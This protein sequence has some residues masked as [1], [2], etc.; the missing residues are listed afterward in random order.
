MS[1]VFPINADPRFRIYTAEDGQTAF[2]VPFPWQDNADIKILRTDLDDVTTTLNEA[3]HYQLTGAGQ[4]GGGTMT[5]NE[6]E[7]A[8]EG[9]EFLILG[10]ASLVRVSSIVQGG[11]FRYQGTDNDLDRLTII[12][13]E[14]ER[15]LGRALRTPYGVA[16]AEVE[17]GTD[18]TLARWVGGR[19][20]PGPIWG[21]EIG[22]IP[23]PGLPPGGTPGQV[24]VRV[25]GPDYETEWQ[26]P[27]S[28][29]DKLPLDGSSPLT[30]PIRFTHQG[31]PANPAAGLLSLFAKN[32]NK[33]YSR[34]ADGTER[35]IG[36]G[37]GGYT[38]PQDHN[39]VVD[40]VANDYA[41]II[42]ARDYAIANGLSLAFPDGN[43][44]YGTTLE[45]A[46][47]GLH[48]LALG[49]AVNLI[50][51]GSGRAVSFNG[52][53]AV[54]MTIAAP[55]VV[56]WA[57]NT[58]ADGNLITFETT[59]ALPTGVTAGTGYYVKN[60]SGNTFE[61]SATPGGASINTTGSQSGVHTG[62]VERYDQSFGG[63][64][65][66]NIR[67]NANTTDLLYTNNVH[68]S[69]FRADVRDGSA[70]WR[71]LFA[72]CNTYDIR[73]SD[74]TGAFA[75]QPFWGAFISGLYDCQCTLILEGVGGGGNYG[76]HVTES[77]NNTFYGTS[78]GNDSGGTY[79]SATAVRNT[80]IGFDCEV[81]GTLEDWL[82]E[83]SYNS[84]IGC[85]GYSTTL[86]TS[87]VGARNSFIG[88]YI[89]P[90]LAVS[91]AHN[92]FDRCEITALGSIAA[93]AVFEKCLVAG[94]LYNKNHDA[95][96]VMGSSG[97]N[98]TQFAGGTTNYITPALAST[99]ESLAYLAFPK[100]GKIRNFHIY[101]QGS[102]G[103]S[104]TYTA[105]VR[106]NLADTAVTAQIAAGF[107]T[108]SDTTHE[109]TVAAGQRWSVKLVTSATA[110]AT[111]LIFAFD[112]IP[113]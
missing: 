87:V 58:L 104:Q 5:L 4:T 33:F 63:A 111:N 25:A 112:F 90:T 11:R 6:G 110:A 75:K 2:S 30:G 76:L 48:V 12:A 97:A 106:V 74:K 49:A 68:H 17:P 54:T 9:E 20:V 35:Q 61:L 21:D 38:T 1:Q 72:V 29:A 66:F 10:K 59:G 99:T 57:G 46:R 27:A 39:A 8:L 77:F 37:G 92:K 102:P 56:T 100:A 40:G 41:A 60:K 96:T 67:G 98:A 7:E 22:G 79:L 31:S 78:E 34:A 70:G 64:H 51:T 88:C 69:G 71:N 83:G 101:S 107:N 82:I 85:V 43:Y 55:V 80:F 108:A 81:N 73:C 53:A 3:E 94:A 36:A 103:A 15:E 45:F 13:Q 14:I 95:V 113:D 47:S 65:K 89:N 62:K 50:H 86:G 18:N 44:S 91:G 16:G 93:T 105:T 52:N 23:G 26:T 32:D 84:F 19:L 24:P 109:A 28:S 42:A